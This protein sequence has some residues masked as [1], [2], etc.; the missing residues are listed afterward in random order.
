MITF[1]THF[2]KKLFVANVEKQH[3]QSLAELRGK[4]KI[5]VIFLAIDKSVWKVDSVFNLMLEDPSF[6]PI[7]LVCPYI[8]DTEAQMWQNMEAACDYFEQKNYPLISSYNKSE[9]RWIELAEIKPDIVFF[10]NPH[11]LTKKEYY[12]DAY[13]N[14]PS[15]YVPYYFMATK[16]V[17]EEDG[18]FNSGFF[19]S[20][21]KIYWPH[22][23]CGQ[24]HKKL[25]MNKGV[26]GLVTG[27]PA[28]ESLVN[29][30]NLTISHCWK[31]QEKEL[32]KIIF[33]PHHTID[34]SKNALS[35]FLIFGEFIQKLAIANKNRAQ[36]SFKP[37]PVLKSKLY[38]HPDWGVE[39]TDAYYSF[40]KEQGFTQLN[41]GGYD[42]L[43]L[44]SDAI[45]HDCS[46]FIVEYAFTGKPCLYLVNK[47]NLKG[48]LNEFGEG[49]IQVYEKAKT[50]E[51]IEAFVDSVIEGSI[52]PDNNKR[53]YFDAYVKEYYKEK[54]PSEC[55]IGDIKQSL[56]I[57]SDQ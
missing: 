43:F 32:A 54:L 13:S 20:A 46:S 24:Q 12:E 27:Y 50:I 6:E 53:T 8:R 44:S 25:S 11:D 52:K 2:K 31:A 9:Q 22:N 56:G 35:S 10:T 1:F 15:V 34:D 21:W 7:I 3:Q 39:K 45:I 36:W 51:E 16:H 40:W 41:E 38:T 4:D 48:L 28:V 30:E 47:N 18:Q 19:L 49:V 42:D 5:K 26:N 14:Y 33:A 57:L 17:G 29:N 55:I 23:Y 37:H